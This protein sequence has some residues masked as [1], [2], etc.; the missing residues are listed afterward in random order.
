MHCHKEVRSPHKMQHRWL[1]SADLHNT[2][3]ASSRF[4]V[5]LCACLLLWSYCY[6]IRV[7]KDINLHF[8]ELI[9]NLGEEEVTLPVILSK[10]IHG[11]ILSC[12]IVAL[13]FGLG[14]HIFPSLDL[15]YNLIIETW[16]SALTLTHK[17]AS[18][19]TPKVQEKGA[20]S[21]KMW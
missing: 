6:V 21:N 3:N 10:Q 8:T 15:I 1:I 18:T 13:S 12:L 4:L 20:G 11:G 19:S 5:P 17:S 9:T 16:H 2:H 7:I 14:K